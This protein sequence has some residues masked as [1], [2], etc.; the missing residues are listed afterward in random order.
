MDSKIESQ[1][2]KI[3]RDALTAAEGIR[4]PKD[5]FIEGLERIVDELREALQMHRDA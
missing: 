1:F 3:A 5:D 4:C 2:A